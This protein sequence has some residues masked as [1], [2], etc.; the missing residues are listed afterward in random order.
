M[1]LTL[2][3]SFIGTVFIIAVTPGP[4]V[5][6]ASANSMNY[7]T[8]KTVGTIFGDLSANAIQ[9]LLSSLGLASIV[10]S[11][12]DIFGLIKWIGVGYLIYMGVTK[13][14]SKPNVEQFKKEN[15]EKDFLKLYSEGFF[16]SASNPKAIVFF[17]ALFPL[18]IDESLAFAPQ[19]LLLGITYLL[20]DGISLFMYVRFASR[21]KKYLENKEKI[22]LQNKIIGSLL[23]FSGVLLSMVRRT[24][25]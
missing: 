24:N 15:R 6:L 2:W 1:N 23:I 7:G 19:V 11:S 9:I 25:T 13:I 17:A 8:K 10:I 5:L 22:H 4:S 21:L 18:F 20:I 12:G 3:I 14:I 16:M